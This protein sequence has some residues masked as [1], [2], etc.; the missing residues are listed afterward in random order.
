[1]N[2]RPMIAALARRLAASGAL[3]LATALVVPGVAVG[4]EPD[5]QPIDPVT[6][7]A[8]LADHFWCEH[9]AEMADGQPIDPVTQ[10]AWLADHFWCEHH[11]EMADA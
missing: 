7:A 11:A 5:G 10:A 3:V 8:W 1:M 4:A 6:Q 9:H 2:T